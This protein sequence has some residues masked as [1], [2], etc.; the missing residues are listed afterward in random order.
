ML[1]QQV[2]VDLAQE[3]NNVCVLIEGS[4]K[5][6]VLPAPPSGIYFL[7]DNTLKSLPT[8]D[9]D[10]YSYDGLWEAMGLETKD[11]YF[12]L[13]VRPYLAQAFFS[14]YEAY[15]WIAIQGLQNS[16]K[17]TAA[18][19][20]MSLVDPRDNHSKEGLSP[21]GGSTPSVESLIMQAINRSFV[22]IDNASRMDAKVSDVLANIATG[23]VFDARAKYENDTLHTRQM[24]AP[25]IITGISMSG[26]KADMI[27]RVIYIEKNRITSEVRTK[28]Q[29]YVKKFKSTQAQTLGAMFM[30][31]YAILAN[32]EFEALMNEKFRYPEYFAGVQR[33]ENSTEGPMKNALMDAME[34]RLE[35]E[36]EGD[37]FVQAIA[38]FLFDRA[39]KEMPADH[40]PNEDGDYVLVVKAT[41]TEL[42]QHYKA[43][44]QIPASA[45][46]N[47]RSLARRL[48]DKATLLEVAGVVFHREAKRGRN[49]NRPFTVNFGKVNPTDPV[50][51][52][53][54]DMEQEREVDKW[55]SA[56]APFGHGPYGGNN[57]H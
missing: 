37:D 32:S 7:R 23:G 4:K 56:E 29:D 8:P 2:F 12:K 41:L 36:T 10:N 26:F 34:E 16:G 33:L 46:I 52:A 13:I 35:E 43:N 18:S 39:K 40:F 30:D 20:I 57:S 24:K 15:P 31:A 54:H 3:G 1:R 55:N 42:L 38:G 49:G 17:T 27:S 44:A 25:G 51:Q 22:G 11:E 50:D 6:E 5:P 47:A 45:N 53:I 21:I 48:S 14:H 19:M 9:F 28:N